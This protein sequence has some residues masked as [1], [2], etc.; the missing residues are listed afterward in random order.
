[1]QVELQDIGKKFRSD[2]VFQHLN[3]VFESQRTTAILGRNGSGKSTLLQLVAGNLSPTNGRIKY[4]RNGAEI[5]N[6]TVFRQLALVAPYQELIEEFT[7]REMVDFHFTFKKYL[8][9]YNFQ[10]A[11]GILG[12]KESPNKQIRQ[13]SSGMKQRIKLVLAI[14]S[15]VPLLLLDEPTMHLDQTGTDWYLSM[16]N[17]FTKNRTLLIC[18]NHRQTEIPSSDAALP[19]GDYQK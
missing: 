5:D 15:D 9:G 13:Y 19:I 16:M 18:S 7:L 10:K 2:W 11:L 14:L 6:T 4:Y 8:A 1:M 3:F 17:D 12:F